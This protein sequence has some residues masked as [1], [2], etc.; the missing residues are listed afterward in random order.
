MAITGVTAL[1]LLDALGNTRTPGEIAEDGSFKVKTAITVRST[2]DA[3]YGFWRGLENLP[4]FMA[5]VES[6]ETA[7][8]RRS[9]WT[10][11]GPAGRTVE[12]DAE[13][14]EDRPN[15]LIAWRSL[16]GSLVK[17]SGRVRFVPAPGD[18][19]TE[20]HLDMQYSPP[21]GPA[22]AGLARLFGEEPEQQAKDDLRRFKQVMETGEVVRSEG[23]PEGIFSRRLMKQRPAQPLERSSS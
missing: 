15:Q 3:V 21:G 6:V 14:V 2:P 22:A 23:S 11:N 1:D 16:P 4:R 7:G 12:W 20:V 10:V 5:H 17:H 18:R 9:H 19:G 13:T 8:D